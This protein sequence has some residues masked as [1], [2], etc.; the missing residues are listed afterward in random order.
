MAGPDQRFA[1]FLQVLYFKGRSNA[2]VISGSFM[3]RHLSLTLVFHEAF[4][5]MS[6]SGPDDIREAKGNIGRCNRRSTNKQEDV[7]RFVP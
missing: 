2:G 7:S 3:H 4:A 1:S 5:M 6:F